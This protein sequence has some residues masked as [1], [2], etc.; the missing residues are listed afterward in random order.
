MR[1]NKQKGGGLKVIYRRSV[2]SVDKN[3]A[4]EQII[5]ETNEHN[6]IGRACE[7][8]ILYRKSGNGCDISLMNNKKRN[9]VISTI[10][11]DLQIEKSDVNKV[12]NFKIESTKHYSLFMEQRKQL[13]QEQ[14]I[15][16]D[17]Y[18]IREGTHCSGR[19]SDCPDCEICYFR[20]KDR[21]CFPCNYRRK[22]VVNWLILNRGVCK[23]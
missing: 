10:M 14:L 13:T 6:C 22:D 1:I 16:Q 2:R 3:E 4:I 7:S 15:T 5:N 12:I 9:A 23:C 18:F 21:S 20:N 17:D 19:H 8:C 11:T